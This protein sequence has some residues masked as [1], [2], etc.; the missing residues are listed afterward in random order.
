MI[1]RKLAAIVAVICL[2]GSMSLPAGAAQISDEM[3]SVGSEPGFGY[4]GYSAYPNGAAIN[5]NSGLIGMKTSNLKVDAITWCKTVNDASCAD[6]DFFQYVSILPLCKLANDVDCLEGVSATSK[7]GTDL[8][9][10]NI[11]PFTTTVRHEFV[12]SSTLN[13]PSGDVPTLFDVPGAPHSGGITYMAVVGSYGSWDKAAGLKASVETGSIAI[14]A[15]KLENGTYNVQEMSTD[16]TRY[17]QRNWR[18]G[19][20]NEDRCKFTDSQKCA[21][22]VP[23][24]LDIKFGVKVRYSSAIKGWFHG[25]VQDPNVQYIDNAGG[26]K[27]LI[28]SAAPVQ[29]PAISIWKK[30]SELPAEVKAFYEKAPKPLGGTGS[31]AG[32]MALQQGPED[33]WSLM[34]QN[35]TGF[36]EGQMQE[37]LT[38]LPVVGDKANMLPTVWTLSLMTNFNSGVIGNTCGSDLNELTGIVSTNSSQYLAGP[39]TFN[40]ATDELEYKVA[41]PHL[42]PNGELSRGTY[43]LTLKSDFAKCLYGITGTA[44]KATISIV[45]ENGQ[46]INAVTTIG[47]KNGWLYL[48]AKGFTYSSPTIKVKLSQDAPA[49]TPSVSPTPTPIAAPAAAKK[50]S[51]TCI[52]GKTSKKVTAVNPTCPK[53]FK[54]K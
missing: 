13:L 12:G 53:G 4:L 28:V 25:R 38:W 49:P 44:I 41:G 18:I 45:S 35:N 32:N 19:A 2:A 43:D 16:A 14:Y 31:G 10:N 15:V 3:Y 1:F 54:K 26:G 8:S 23:L 42:L 40:K 24:P 47:E 48:S 33:G 29:V 17:F 9:V 5:A 21:V 30:K 36:S 46:S 37:F 7:D 34:L 20:S 52:K 50:T 51:I 39:P 22:A 6:K 11:V 27:T